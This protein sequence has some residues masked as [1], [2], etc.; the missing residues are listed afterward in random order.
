MLHITQDRHGHHCGAPQLLAV[1]WEVPACE[2]RASPDRC[3]I[4]AAALLRPAL[5]V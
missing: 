1:S 3:E 2:L 4:P 5:P